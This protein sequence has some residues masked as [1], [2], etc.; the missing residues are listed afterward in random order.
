MF[1]NPD[2]MG[3]QRIISTLGGG[4]YSVKVKPRCQR[5]KQRRCFS[6]QEAES[7]TT[8]ETEDDAGKMEERWKTFSSRSDPL[9][10]TAENFVFLVLHSFPCQRRIPSRHS[11]SEP[12][13]SFRSRGLFRMFCTA[14]EFS[15]EADPR[16]CHGVAPTD[17]CGACGRGGRSQAASATRGQ[18]AAVLNT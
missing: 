16:F 12:R 1:T 14:E 4:G 10:S 11:R 13:F 15:S 17:L 2:P 5:R 3:V 6:S 8:S 18:Q 7:A 9:F